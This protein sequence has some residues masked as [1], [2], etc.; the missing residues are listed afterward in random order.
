[1]VMFQIP[2]VSHKLTP[3]LFLKCLFQ[4]VSRH[5]WRGEDFCLCKPFLFAVAFE[6]KYRCVHCA[7]K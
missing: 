7:L 5:V 4:R 6:T 1:M 3:R 2:I